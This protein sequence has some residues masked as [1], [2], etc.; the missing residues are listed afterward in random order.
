MVLNKQQLENLARGRAIR[1][2]NL[3]ARQ[4]PRR[5]RYVKV[6]RNAQIINPKFLPQPINPDLDVSRT[7]AGINEKMS[8]GE[9]LFANLDDVVPRVLQGRRR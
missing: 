2:A 9:S 4:L 6:P 5:N 1:M 8:S 7:D 3:K